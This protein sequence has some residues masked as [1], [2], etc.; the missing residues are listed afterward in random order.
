MIRSR[1]GFV[2]WFQRGVQQGHQPGRQLTAHFLGAEVHV[3][4]L[5]WVVAAGELSE[6]SGAI[7]GWVAGLE[8]DIYDESA[9]E[10][11]MGFPDAP[12]SVMVNSFT[13]EVEEDLKKKCRLEPGV[14]ILK[15]Q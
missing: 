11:Q 14:V 9:D 7:D 6:R 8:S 12:W 4:P 3:G 13:G 1:E 5:I 15:I 10:G 2:V